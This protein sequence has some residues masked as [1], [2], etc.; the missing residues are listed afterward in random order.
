[1]TLIADILLG[2]GALGVGIY[3]HVLAT[4]LRRFTDLERGMG[5]AVAVL[6]A[7]VDD[8]NRAV[9]RARNEAAAQGAQLRAQ[10]EKAEKAAQRLELLVAALHDLPAEEAPARAAPP[11]RNPFFVRHPEPGEAG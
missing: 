1:M 2:A 10:T 4:R 9:A 11:A 5:G 7:Q 6:S 8:L 3:C